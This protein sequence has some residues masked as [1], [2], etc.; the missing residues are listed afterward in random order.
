MVPKHGT[1]KPVGYIEGAPWKVTDT[2]SGYQNC[3]PMILVTG[4]YLRD[5]TVQ[6]RGRVSSR[7]SE[8]PV[9]AVMWYQKVVQ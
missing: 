5:C 1:I 6:C 2:Q 4:A 8:R 7:N 3:Q 9:V